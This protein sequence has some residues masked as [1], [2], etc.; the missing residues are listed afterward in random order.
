MIKN[1]KNIKKSGFTLIEVL[2]VIGIVGILATVVLAAVNPSRQFKQARD[3]QRLANINAILNAVGQNMVDHEGNI[4]CDGQILSLIP[5][6][7]YPITSPLTTGNSADLAS[8]LVPDYLT[9]MPYDPG[10]NYA[11]Y[12]SETD[13]NTGYSMSIDSLGRVTIMAGGELNGEISVTR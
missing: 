4:F 13:Y 7:K 1:N 9:K 5:G 3:S 6:E 2:V 8:C 11:K 12:V 10:L